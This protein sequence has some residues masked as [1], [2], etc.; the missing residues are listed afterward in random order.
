MFI[1]E[2]PLMFSRL[3]LVVELLLG[4]AARRLAVRA[5]A[6]AA[7]R[8]HVAGRAPRRRAGLAGAGTLLVHGAG[9]DLL[10]AC[11]RTSPRSF[12]LSLMCSY[13]RARFVPFLTPRGG[14]ANPLS[15]RLP[16]SYRCRGGPKRRRYDGCGAE[17][18][19]RWPKERDW[20]S[21]TRSQAGSR[22][23]IPP[24]PSPASWRAGPIPAPPDLLIRTSPG[25]RKRRH[26]ES[27]R[28]R[29][30]R[31]SGAASRTPCGRRHPRSTREYS[32]RAARLPVT[33]SSRSGR[34]S[35]SCLRRRACGRCRR[36]AERGGRSHFRPPGP[37]QRPPRPRFRHPPSPPAAGSLPRPRFGQPPSPPVGVVAPGAAGWVSKGNFSAAP[38]LFLLPL[39]EDLDDRQHAYN[40]ARRRPQ[41]RGPILLGRENPGFRFG[42]DDRP[43]KRGEDDEDTHTRP[44]G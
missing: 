44:R 20:K 29:A 13:W 26:P 17:R 40:E 11:P 24:S 28:R 10:G 25:P 21:R 30:G 8:G 27:R 15:A 39:A 16:R 35:R 31:R 38:A 33:T 37:P 2:R 9:G 12:A 18:C 22:V 23:R 32:T 36:P 43:T 34:P 6:A 19:P 5:K 14:I 41:R 7:A 3:R 42:S 1:C 4:P